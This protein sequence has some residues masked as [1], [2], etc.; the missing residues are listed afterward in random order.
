VTTT[1]PPKSEAFS[2]FSV[3]IITPIIWTDSDDRNA[4]ITRLFQQYSEGQ[5]LARSCPTWLH[6]DCHGRPVTAFNRLSSHS[7]PR[8]ALDRLRSTGSK[9]KATNGK[10]PW[11]ARH[12]TFAVFHLCKN[13]HWVFT[14]RL[15]PP[16]QSVRG[17][18]RIQFCGRIPSAWAFLDI[19][20]A[21]IPTRLCQSFSNLSGGNWGFSGISNCSIKFPSA[22]CQ[23]KPICI[24]AWPWR[25]SA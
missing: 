10:I 16:H 20:E 5:L 11:D 24:P 23:S 25:G 12:L 15:A 9:L 2:F 6:L 22:R 4:T 17:Q 14:G 13:S 3:S 1:Y 7:R 21:V 19:K 18:V 8:T